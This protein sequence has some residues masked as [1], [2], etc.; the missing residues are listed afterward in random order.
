[1]SKGKLYA[2]VDDHN[3]V[4]ATD[5]DIECVK[6]MADYGNRI[7]KLHEVPLGHENPDLAQAYAERSFDGYILAIWNNK[8]YVDESLEKGSHT[9]LL[10]E[11]E[12]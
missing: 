9:I 10:Q 12:K 11:E 8:G 3:K 5:D 6:R 1:M 7:V 4:L 2:E